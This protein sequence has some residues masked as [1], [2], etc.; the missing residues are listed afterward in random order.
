MCILKQRHKGIISYT[1]QS[2]PDHSK[3]IKTRCLHEAHVTTAAAL[4]HILQNQSETG[5]PLDEPQ[6][7]SW[8]SEWKVSPK[9]KN[10]AK[11]GYSIKECRMVPRHQEREGHI[12]NMFP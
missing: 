2:A 11:N 4:I 6:T 12:A 8:T 7:G 1:S 9:V 10:E 5:L 3:Q